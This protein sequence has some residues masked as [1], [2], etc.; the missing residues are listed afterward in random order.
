MPEMM[1]LTEERERSVYVVKE[2]PPLGVGNPDASI[3]YKKQLESGELTAE[4]AEAAIEFIKSGEGMCPLTD[5]DDGC[6]DGRCAQRVLFVTEEGEFYE[7]DIDDPSEHLRAKVA[8]GGYITSL[9]MRAGLGSVSHSLDSDLALVIDD[10]A[11]QNMYCGAHTGEHGHDEVTDCGANDKFP[12]IIANGVLYKETIAANTIAL[13]REAGVTVDSYILDMVFD[14]WKTAIDAQYGEDGTGASRFEVIESGLRKSQQTSGSKDKP[15]AVTK[16][17]KGTHKED[18]IVV[19]YHEGKTFLQTA[20]ADHLREDFP[21]K[22]AQAFVVDVPRIVALAAAQA[23]G[24][25]DVFNQA[26]CA[27][28][29]FQL[30]T[31]ATLTDG[32]LRTFIVN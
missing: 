27:G 7:R 5:H 21:D 9:A 13:I 3:S 10:L 30:A 16:E 26:L 24:D 20:L 2:I 22:S 32:T 12:Q 29:A 15:V 11:A 23:N 18:F 25:E 1:T 8:G 28:V 6:I 14:G 31:A 17:L 4:V 19:N